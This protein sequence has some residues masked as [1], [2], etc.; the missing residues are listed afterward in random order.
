MVPCDAP[1]DKSGEFET[2]SAA[3]LMEL[4]RCACFDGSQDERKA[5]MAQIANLLGHPDIPAELK[6]VAM[7]AVERLA[8]R[9]SAESACQRGLEEMRRRFG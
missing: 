4:L 1:P 6:K 7:D 2:A 9:G 5:C 8:R 3:R